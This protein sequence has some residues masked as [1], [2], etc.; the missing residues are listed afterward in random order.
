M[1]NQRKSKTNNELKYVYQLAD[2]TRFNINPNENNELV[3]ILREMDKR[4][5]L[6]D[7]Y[8]NEAKDQIFEHS[9]NEYHKKPDTF[10]NSPLDSIVDDNFSIEHILFND[11]NETKISDKV[12]SIIPSLK[13]DQQEL[14]YLLCE[15]HKL[16]DIAKKLNISSEAVRSRVRKMKIKI[17]KLYQEKYGDY[18]N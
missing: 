10:T 14:W 12:H 5:R 11:S 3:T 18:I 2:G 13:K 15:G 16:V 9:K 17:K 1:A 7:R 4:E 6:T 8:E